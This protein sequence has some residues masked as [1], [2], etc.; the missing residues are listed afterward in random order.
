[1]RNEFLK[2]IGHWILCTIVASVAI[3]TIF[4]LISLIPGSTGLPNLNR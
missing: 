4:E 3:V 2:L 1:M